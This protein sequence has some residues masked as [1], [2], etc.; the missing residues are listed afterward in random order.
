MGLPIPP[1]EFDQLREQ[2][3][4]LVCL[5]EYFFIPSS[6][7]SQQETLS[8]RSAILSSLKDYSLRLG[9]TVVGGSLV[10]EEDGELFAAS[11]VFD[12]G[13]HIGFYRKMHPTDHERRVGIRPGNQPVV[14]EI[15][16]LRLGLLVCADVL[17][18]ESVYALASLQPDL[19]AIPTASP[20]RPNDT[21]EEKFL[22]DREIFLAAAR[23]TR[24][25]ILKTCGVGSLMGEKL[26]GRSLICD[27]RG[28]LARVAPNKEDEEAILT[29]SCPSS[30]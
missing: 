26:Q 12:R 11:H 2:G 22:R 14:L 1:D 21:V 3:I 10:E 24:G 9:G 13:R 18:P 7:R 28:F 27:S 8:L 15:R 5:P 23:I 6:I 30:G 4:E 17:F 20:Y 19:I 25:I 29:A 16:G